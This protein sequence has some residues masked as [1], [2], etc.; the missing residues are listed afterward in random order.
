[1]SIRMVQI[2][3]DMVE[4]KVGKGENTIDHIV[5]KKASLSTLLKIDIAQKTIF[6]FPTFF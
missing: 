5:F 1:M 2:V 6:L 3:F 4:N